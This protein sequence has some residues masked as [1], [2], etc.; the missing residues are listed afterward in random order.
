[1]K[2]RIK[3]FSVGKLLG[4]IIS[5]PKTIYFNFRALPLDQAIKLPIFLWYNVSILSVK[6]GVIHFP[7][8]V[9]PF[10]IGI[11]KGGTKEVIANP[12]SQISVGGGS[13][14][15]LGA[16]GFASGISLDCT[17]DMTIGANFS[18]NKNAFISCSK[19][20][21]IGERVMLGDNCVIRDSDGHTVTLNGMAKVSQRPIFI[22]NHVWI[23]SHAHVLKGS[24]IADNSIVAY[25]SLVTRKFEQEGALIAGLP[26]T[27]VQTG[28]DWGV[29]DSEKERC[30]NS[31]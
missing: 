21:V 18:T 19:K 1:M 13:L 6:K 11:G 7:N 2:N 17:G 8:G 22:G 5:F 27:V 3:N 25:R 30:D 16:A 23:A 15:F 14:S 12:H 10:M 4:I 20:I 26:A 24:Y 9:R 28:I 31:N 29:Y